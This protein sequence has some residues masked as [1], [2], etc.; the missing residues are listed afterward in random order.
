MPSLD[1]YRDPEITLKFMC[2]TGTMYT[3]TTYLDRKMNSHYGEADIIIPFLQ[4]RA[5]KHRS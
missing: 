3:D 4:M 1:K 2:F 5:L